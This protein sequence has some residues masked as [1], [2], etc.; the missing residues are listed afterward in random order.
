MSNYNASTSLNHPVAEFLQPWNSK[1]SKTGGALAHGFSFCAF[2]TSKPQDFHISWVHGLLVETM[3]LQR[4]SNLVTCTAHLFP[5]SSD[6]IMT[7]K[8]ALKMCLMSWVHKVSSTKLPCVQLGCGKLLMVVNA[9]AA[10][11]K[12]SPWLQ[13][14]HLVA[15]REWVETICILTFHLGCKNLPTSRMQRLPGDH[16]RL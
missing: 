14:H 10:P 12:N 15:A 4:I 3:C 5:P 6:K 11:K 8:N 13:E 9:L 7:Q 16:L 1:H 2:S